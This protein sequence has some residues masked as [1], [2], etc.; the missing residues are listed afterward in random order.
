MFSFCFQLV[1]TIAHLQVDAAEEDR[2]CFLL[3]LQRTSSLLLNKAPCPIILI[4]FL[5]SRFCLIQD[6]EALVWYLPRRARKDRFTPKERAARRKQA[7][8]QRQKVYRFIFCDEDTFDF[9]DHF[10][11]LA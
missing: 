4:F 7:L 8:E 6:P 9:Q 5:S 10:Y 2:S 3:F 1:F 11:G